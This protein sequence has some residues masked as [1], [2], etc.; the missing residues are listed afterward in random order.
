MA[1]SLWWD[2][3]DQTEFVRPGSWTL[4]KWDTSVGTKP[5][6]VML[7]NEDNNNLFLVRLSSFN[8]TVL[9]YLMY[10]RSFGKHLEHC[11]ILLY[12]KNSWGW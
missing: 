6:L 3:A 5:Y 1:V 10:I 9:D 2:E 12:I 8:P 7:N 4:Q 11:T